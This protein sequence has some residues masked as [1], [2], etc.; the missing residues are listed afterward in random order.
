MMTKLQYPYRL[1]VGEKHQFCRTSR[2]SS[3]MQLTYTCALHGKKDGGNL[4]IQ[5]AVLKMNTV[6]N[7]AEN[8]GIV[9]EKLVESLVQTV[10][11]KKIVKRKRGGT[12]C[13]AYGCLKRRKPL[14]A[15]RSDSSGTSNE[16]SRIKRTVPRTFHSFPDDKK[17]DWVRRLRRDKAKD[18]WTPKSTSRICSDHFLERYI[19]R[20][21]DQQRTYLTDD[22]IP[23][24]F[25]KI[26]NHLHTAT[27][28]K[29]KSPRKRHK[30]PTFTREDASNS[31]S[32]A[33][34]IESTE[35]QESIVENS[36]STENIDLRTV[37][38]LERELERTRT[39]LITVKKKLKHSQQRTRRLKKRLQ[40]SKEV[41]AELR[42]EDLITKKAEEMI[43][44]TLSDESREIFQ[45]I[46][47]GDAGKKGCEFPP[48]LK[49]FALTLQF[50]STKAYD[51]VREKLNKALPDRSTLRRWYGK[52]PA[53]PGFTQ[54]A[55]IVLREKAEEMKKQGKELHC[56]LM[57]DEM[58]LRKL[59]QWVHNQHRYSG[60]VDL[61]ND[62]ADDED[63]DDDDSPKAKDVL[64]FMVVHV[65]GNWKVPCAYFFID[66]LSG[67]ERANLI[68]LCIERLHDVGVSVASLTC[69]G[70][71]CH[72]TM[73]S[74]LGATISFPEK[75]IDGSFPHP[76]GTGFVRVFL[77][78]CHMLKLVRNTLGQRKI[79]LDKSNRQILWQYIVNLQKLQEAEG[80]RLGNR[81]TKAHIH[82]EAQK[83]KVNLAAQALSS[84][85]ADAIEYCDKQLK[86]PQFAG[87]EA[88]VEF[89][90][91][92]DR[93]F[94]ILNSRSIV[95]KNFKS[96]LKLSN[97]W[98]WEPFLAEAFTYIAHLKDGNTG[99]YMCLT[100]RKTG[101]IG[102]LI[103]IQ[104]TRNIY[105]DLVETGK[106]NF[107]LMYKFSQ[108]F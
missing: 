78:A 97:K 55:F 100:K 9:V 105:A 32:L 39:E 82:W 43:N 53:D 81:L 60:F 92:F 65:N 25:K 47:N 73:L 11:N 94:D 18:G 75:K 71:S 87:S 102:F 14:T 34:Y 69:D 23:T 22:A 33:D 90:R 48:E 20:E 67:A 37:E 80:L 89:I 106:L 24:R 28:T 101:F 74:S 77:D 21:P 3:F 8:V 5:D 46:I 98:Q 93:L 12:Q 85:V 70:P 38:D 17:D 84:S 50:Y 6:E 64:V 27:K 54:P 40:T 79:L 35:D 4:T 96:P 104:S 107:I 91:L 59:I 1:S 7:A 31:E 88:T 51:F 68:R 29:R 57:L 56:A 95:A 44:K 103:C 108:H 41:I 42:R 58:S 86:L 72:F 2:S 13:V 99:T 45:R 16:E 15:E 52:I 36:S 61:G 30:S 10:A 66:G 19:R 62:V 76:N 26:P 83:M 63:S 49:S